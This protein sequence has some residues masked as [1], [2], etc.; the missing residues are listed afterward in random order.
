[1]GIFL[2]KFDIFILRD[3][4]FQNDPN[5]IVFQ[6]P[7]H[8]KNCF[9]IWSIKLTSA[10]KKSG[11]NN[12]FQVKI[13]KNNFISNLLEIFR[14]RRVRKNLEIFS[15]YKILDKFW[16]IVYFLQLV[17]FLSYFRILVPNFSYIF[18]FKCLNRKKV[19]YTHIRANN[20]FL[21]IN[22]QNQHEW[23]YWRFWIFVL[24]WAF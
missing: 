19:R 4:N 16:K 14:H 3:Q 9:S 24:K 20:L 22:P 11:L 13:W 6:E 18:T 12:E 17:I 7:K 21:R 5:I 2:W 15:T 8:Q 23:R 10:S 1:M